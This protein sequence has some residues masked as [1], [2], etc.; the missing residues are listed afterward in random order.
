MPTPSPH[1]EAT[2]RTK[3]TI[4]THHCN[5]DVPTLP[6]CFVQRQMAGARTEKARTEEAITEMERVYAAVLPRYPITQRRIKDKIAF[7]NFRDIEIATLYDHVSHITFV[8]SAD[9]MAVVLHEPTQDLPALFAS[10]G[11]DVMTARL[12]D[13]APVPDRQMAE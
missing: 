6:C 8:P 13:A 2:M 12:I 10:R 11:I 3:S 5:L 1:T 9:L 7:L 4:P